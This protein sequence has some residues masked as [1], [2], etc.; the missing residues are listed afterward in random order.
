MKG[1]SEVMLATS[2]E[3]A[4][5]MDEGHTILSFTASS[6]GESKVSFGGRAVHFHDSRTLGYAF[7]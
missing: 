1:S 7:S 4:E 6:E 3:R 5:D 2:E